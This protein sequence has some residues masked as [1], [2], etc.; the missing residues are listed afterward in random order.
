M[1]TRDTSRRAAVVVSF[2]GVDITK[3]LR[4]YLKSITFTDSEADETDDLQLRLQDRDG[5]WLESWIGAAVDAAASESGSEGAE[6]GSGKA[7]AIGDIVNFTGNKHYVSSTGD[8]GY[9][10]KPGPGR[11]TIIN[12]GAKHPYHLIHT[13]GTTNLYGWVDA[14]DISGSSSEAV[15]GSGA[16]SYTVTPSIGLNVR[17]GPGTTYGKLGALA[18][19]EA[20]TVT[21]IA[22]G[23]GTIDYRGKTGYVSMQYLQGT[24][25]TE[26]AAAASANTGLKI[27]AVITMANRRSDGK[28]EVLNCGI[29]E[30]DSIDAD[31]PPS[32]ITIKATSLP[33][34]STVRQTKKSR[35]WESYTLKGIAEEM[36]RNN[37]MACLFL[38]G[39]DPFY[40]RVEQFQQSDIAFLETLCTAA[41]ISLKATNQ[42]LV[43]F[44]QAD[45]EAKEP[46]RTIP[47]GE[48]GGYIEYHL[49]IGK[50]ET[51]YQSCRVSYNDP[52]TGKSIQGIAKVA[53]WKESEDNQQLE[54]TAKVGSV[55]EA[56][57]MARKYLRLHNK[58]EKTVE[59]E[60]PGDPT[61]CAGCTVELTGWGPWTGKHIIRQATH[62]V[63]AEG[64]YTT[65]I[66]LRRVLE[67]Y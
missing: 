53:D 31:G 46:V 63:D 45:Y 5:I 64:G 6:A 12:P 27:E 41:G 66:S 43:L 16:G 22:G 28:D 55:G 36:A 47:R 35:G 42:M 48:K 65:S 4:P 57:T 3:D 30:L 50:A 44:D 59:I 8:R 54:I 34:S 60:L 19:G 15:A 2:G 52:G 21:S 9:T 32:E 17:K 56:E 37:R 18:K 67:G 33:Y 20:V 38:S 29:F 49:H 58:Y 40:E 11:V 62:T 13:D 1:S 7:P 25:K 10:T 39:T 23:W 51:E 26:E 24:G 14:K 61:L